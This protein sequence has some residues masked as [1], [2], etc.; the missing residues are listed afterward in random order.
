MTVGM[1]NTIQ[2]QQVIATIQ[3]DSTMIVRIS[4]VHFSGCT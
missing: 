1:F 3:P 2:A 4:E